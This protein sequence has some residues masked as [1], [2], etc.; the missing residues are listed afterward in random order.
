[1]APT[2]SREVPHTQ[3]QAVIFDV[4]NVLILGGPGSTA[5]AQLLPSDTHPHWMDQLTK[6]DLGQLSM[7]DFIAELATAAH[8]TTHQVQELM[9]VLQ[10][11]HELLEFISQHLVQK[12][13]V[14]LLSNGSQVMIEQ[15]LGDWIHCFDPVVVSSAVG[16]VKP[17]PRIF[18]LTMQQCDLAADTILFIDDSTTN[19][20][21]AK[22]AGMQALL[23]QDFPTLKTDLIP[24]GVAEDKP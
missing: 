4:I 16:L 18:A 15:F 8:T 20:M 19:V 5:I 6:L 12:Y 2:D 11:N 7:N 22:R 3:V 23:Y 24:L 14:G 10:L 9:S 1:M 13:R 21:A 17:D